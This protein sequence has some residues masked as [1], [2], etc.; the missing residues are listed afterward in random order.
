MIHFDQRI[1]MQKFVSDKFDTSWKCGRC[2]IGALKLIEPIKTKTAPFSTSVKCTNLH[3]QTIHRVIGKVAFMANDIETSENYHRIDDRRLYPSQFIPEL[4]MF[5]MPLSLDEQIKRLL[6]K[7]FNHFW[8]DLDACANKI[9]QALEL[10]VVGKGGTGSTLDK[11]IKS[12]KTNLGEKLAETLLA[13][14]WIGNDG[15][16]VGRPFA[17][18]E[19]LDAFGLL[20]DVLNQLYPDESEQERRQSL[21]QLINEKKGMK[22]L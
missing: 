6:I 3:C 4:I 2:G 12:I 9:R 13:L 1:W 17:R 20:V 14:K 21:A 7:A 22:N 16:H 15:S 10:I 18:E 8:Y 19:I 11:M 5:E